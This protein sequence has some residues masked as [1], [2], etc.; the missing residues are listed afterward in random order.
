MAINDTAILQPGELTQFQFALIL[1]L[2]FL[3]VIICAIAY[4][5]INRKHPKPKQ[6]SNPIFQAVAIWGILF[7]FYLLFA[8][9]G[10]RTQEEV[11]SDAKWWLLLGIAL[12]LFFTIQ[13]YFYRKAIPSAKLWKFY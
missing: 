5:Y 8:A 11:R 2:V 6:Q 7:L 9:L 13:S 4:F 10:F 3:V 1:W 12:I